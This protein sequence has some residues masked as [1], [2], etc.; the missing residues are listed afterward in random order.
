[1]QHK[2]NLKIIVQSFVDKFR[3]SV[4]RPSSPD[5]EST[6]H[7]LYAKLFNKTKQQLVEVL[8]AENVDTSGK[9]QI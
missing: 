5:P 2:T 1:L 9:K 8:R 7:P 6:G 3:M 4:D